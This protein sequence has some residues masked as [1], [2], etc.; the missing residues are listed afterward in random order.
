MEVSVN[1]VILLVVHVAVVEAY[2]KDI[3]LVINLSNLF[4]YFLSSNK[5][6]LIKGQ[7]MVENIV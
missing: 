6:K 4:K 1:G 7:K 3:E 2:A 5:K